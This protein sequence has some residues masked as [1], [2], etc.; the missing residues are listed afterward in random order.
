[1]AKKEYKKGD[2]YTIPEEG[3]LGLLALGYQGLM[4]WRAKQLGS[5]YEGE[6]LGPVIHKKE[7]R[8][9]TVKS[10]NSKDE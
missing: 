8:V 2:Q 5:Q 9:S 10:K 7:I 1:M 4:M 6:L 3:S